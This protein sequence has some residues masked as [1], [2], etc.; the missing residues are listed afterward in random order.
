V[1]G[2]FWTGIAPDH[3]AAL[4]AVPVAAALVLPAARVVRAHAALGA[5]WARRLSTGWARAGTAER[6]AAA[7]LATAGVVHV[8]LP[9]GHDGGL[10]AAVVFMAGGAAYLWLALRTVT[11]R[12]WRL[13]AALLVVVTLTAYVVAVASGEEADQV[14]LATALVELAALGLA[15]CRR[16]WLGGAVLLLTSLLFGT[17]S[18]IQVAVGH[19]GRGG[20]HD[21]PAAGGPGHHHHGDHLARAQAGIIMR[22][23]ASGTTEEQR[24]AAE[25]LVAEVRAATSAYRDLGA[26]LADGYRFGG[27][28]TEGLDLHLEHKGHKGDGAVLDPTRPEALVYAR[29]GGRAALLGVVF[30]MPTAGARGP[31]VGGATTT[32][33]GHNLC[34]G[35]LPPGFGLVT[36]YGNCPFLTAQLTLPEMMHVWLVDTPAGPFADALPKDRARAALAR[37]G[38]P[39]P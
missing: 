6:W 16:R 21:V 37:A 36:P 24:R 35:L 31:Q 7:L 10:G 29:R 19:E 12:R 17:V 14:G 13:A 18:W 34:V 3:V 8:A 4:L 20:G 25:R 1:T 22:P 39:Y 30:Q 2:D 9:F 11:G 5:G 15:A 33:H 32:W 28:Q 26:A 38:R 27:G 23:G